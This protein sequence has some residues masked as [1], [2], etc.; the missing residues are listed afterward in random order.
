MYVHIQINYFASSKLT[1]SGSFQLRGRKPEYIA[2]QYW[3]QIK[4]DMSYHAQLE[5]VI[6]NG[7]QDITKLV[8]DLEK[9][10]I[11]KSMN[12]NLPF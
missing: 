7:D 2:L 12:D 4:N 3:K 8:L 9:R 6:L 5:K 10:E 11:E 1:Q